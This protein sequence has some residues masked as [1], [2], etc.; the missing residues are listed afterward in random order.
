MT[1]IRILTLTLL[2]LSNP[3]AFAQSWQQSVSNAPQVQLGIRDKNGDMGDFVAEF[4]VIGPS[5]KGSSARLKVRSSE[6]GYVL[7]PADF[8]TPDFN[9]GVYRW[10]ALVAKKPRVG[11]TFTIG[12]TGST[13]VMT[14]EKPQ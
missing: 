13:V 9:P 12:S 14:S 2:A 10:H 5:G 7:Y 3:N 4:V 6:F 8:N 11:G 1:T